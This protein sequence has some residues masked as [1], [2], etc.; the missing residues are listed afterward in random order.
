MHGGNDDAPL[1]ALQSS[2]AHSR[3]V[4]TYFFPGRSMGPNYVP[5]FEPCPWV[6]RDLWNLALE[7]SKVVHPTLLGDSSSHHTSE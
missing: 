1:I 3:C 5:H 2:R 7:H 4:G 6:G